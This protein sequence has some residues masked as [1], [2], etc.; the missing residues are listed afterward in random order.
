MRVQRLPGET[1][2]SFWAR[3]NATAAGKPAPVV[4]KKRGEPEAEEQKVVVEWLRARGY[5]RFTHPANETKRSWFVAKKLKAMGQQPGVLDLFIWMRPP[6]HPEA[7][8]VAIEM[9][10]PGETMAA[11]SEAQEQWIRDLRALGW[12]VRVFFSAREA[13]AWLESLGF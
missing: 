5:E 1:P 12:K 7:G 4:A 3:V 11:V 8:G 13:I 9:K 2:A 6:L 10:A